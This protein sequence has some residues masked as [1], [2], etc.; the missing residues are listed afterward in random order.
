MREFL[1]CEFSGVDALQGWR[2]DR[3]SMLELRGSGV[4]R[5]A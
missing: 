5:S 2:R 4:V 3:G 1:G